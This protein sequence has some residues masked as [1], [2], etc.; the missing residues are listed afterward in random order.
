[1]LWHPTKPNIEYLFDLRLREF[2]EIENQNLNLSTNDW[3]AKYIHDS[4]HEW[5]FYE[6]SIILY[7]WIAQ[8]T[9]KKNNHQGGEPTSWTLELI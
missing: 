1:M 8:F 5:F 7:E 6:I 4:A 2:S 9:Y 3:L